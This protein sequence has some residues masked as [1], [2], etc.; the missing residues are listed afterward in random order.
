MRSR[1]GR[2][3]DARPVPPRGVWSLREI[4]NRKVGDA[5]PQ[6]ILPP[7]IRAYRQTIV[8]DSPLAYWRL[9]E[10]P[11]ATVAVDETG[12]HPG[13]YSAPAGT[14]FE[15]GSTVLDGESVGVR[16]DGTGKLLN[17]E[18]L[19][20]LATNTFTMEFWVSPETTIEID[21]EATSGYGGTAG[22]R[23]VFSPDGAHG[24]SAAR[25]GVAVG[26]NFVGVYEHTDDYMPCLLSYP[27]TLTGWTHIVVVYNNRTP[28]LYVN[29]KFRKTGLTSPKTTVHI[30]VNI[31]NSSYGTLLGGLDEAAIYPSALSENQIR[32]HYLIG[33]GLATNENYKDAVLTD[34]PTHYWRFGGTGTLVDEIGSNDGTYS[35]TFVR[36]VIGAIVKS[37]DGADRFSSNASVNLASAEGPLPTEFS[38]ELWFKTDSVSTDQNVR[39]YLVTRQQDPPNVATYTYMQ[40]HGFMIAGNVV[41]V[42]VYVGGGAVEAITGPTI[43]AGRWY[44]AVL[45]GDASGFRLYLNGIEVASTA[46]PPV[47]ADCNEWHFGA[48]L[49][50][51]GTDYFIGSMDEAAYY[52]HALSP[53]RVRAHYDEGAGL[54][55]VALADPTGANSGITTSNDTDSAVTANRVQAAVDMTIESLDC[56]FG[57]TSSSAQ[58]Q[59][60]LLSEDLSRVLAETPWVV[61]SEMDTHFKIALTEPYDIVAGTVFWI[62]SAVRSGGE[63]T[64]GTPMMRRGP[65]TRGAFGDIIAPPA[66][67]LYRSWSDLARTV[68]VHNLSGYYSVMHLFGLKQEARA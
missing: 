3:F 54:R 16:H 53:A 68:Q 43:L 31:G 32:T 25:A 12:N 66:G 1:I 39:Q 47:S 9:G 37:L 4:A 42:Q 57:A 36:D 20:G 51:N 48:R 56:V 65:V 26:T 34:S 40:R 62:V 33:V 46:T 10:A 29:G 6:F 2:G 67:A 28:S 19:S 52:P 30:P 63:G 24:V 55:T 50:A 15:Y 5:W 41:Q 58:T 35:G 60:Y 17:F 11:G 7:P 22:E 27:V 64:S 8:A 21:A 49:D 18:S 23:Y 61:V 38:Y 59:Y 45:T 13:T 14:T 44:H